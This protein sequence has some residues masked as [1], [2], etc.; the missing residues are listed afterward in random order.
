MTRRETFRGRLVVARWFSS[1]TVMHM[2]NRG[3]SV[4]R[5][6]RTTKEIPQDAAVDSEYV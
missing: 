2:S 5:H 4:S 1:S 6:F 3:S